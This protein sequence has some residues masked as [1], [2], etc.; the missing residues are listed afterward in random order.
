MG[1]IY[2]RGQIR[3][4]PGSGCLLMAKIIKIAEKYGNKCINLSRNGN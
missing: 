4:V 3:S 1:W 2:S